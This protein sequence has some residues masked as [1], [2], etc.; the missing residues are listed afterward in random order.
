MGMIVMGDEYP[1]FTV[2]AVQAASVFFDRD[3]TIDKAVR[4]I[5]E[6]AD[7]G[8]VIIGFPELFIAGHL[9]TWYT[10]KKYNPMQVEKEFFLQLIK[11][12]IKKLVNNSFSSF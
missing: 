3:K 9:G 8:A 1:K 11:N 12:G 5:E 7:K 10:T 4:L 6:A 2:A